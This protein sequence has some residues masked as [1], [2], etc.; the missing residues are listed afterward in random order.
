MTIAAQRRRP[1]RDRDPRRQR[2][3]GDGAVGVDEA[4]PDRR[5]PEGADR[6][7]GRGQRRPNLGGACPWI[8][9]A[10]E[11]RDRRR[12]RRRGRGAAEAPDAGFESG[13]EARHAAIGGDEIGLGDDLLAGRRRG[14]SVGNRAEVVLDRTAR[15]VALRLG[16]VAVADRAD[17]DRRR[18][19]RMAEDGR[20]DDVPAGGLRVLG[21]GD[22]AAVLQQSELESRRGRRARR[23]V[24]DPEAVIDRQPD[25]RA[26]SGVVF[27]LENLDRPLAAEVVAGGAEE[28]LLLSLP[29]LR[30]VCLPNRGG[31]HRDLSGL[32]TTVPP[33]GDRGPKSRLWRR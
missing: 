10:D 18:G 2:Q 4:R 19:P 32:R 30:A 9:L 29:G 16:A 13:E 14:R 17:P 5:R 26:C 7:R 6:A 21:R 31:R 15:G 25:F 12:V 1:L 23:R 24:A 33:T 8:G 20:P 28:R 3:G 22:A 11:G 27:P